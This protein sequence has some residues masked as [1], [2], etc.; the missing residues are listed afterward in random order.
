ME[1]CSQ[2]GVQLVI[3]HQ[4]TVF[5]MVSPYDEGQSFLFQFLVSLSIQ[6]TKENWPAEESKDVFNANKISE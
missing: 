2:A 1:P 6:S 5:C 4:N 3:K